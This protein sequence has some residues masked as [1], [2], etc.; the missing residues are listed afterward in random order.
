MNYIL[1]SK[2]RKVLIDLED[3]EKLSKYKW[4]GGFNNGQIFSKEVGTLSRYLLKCPPNLFVDHINH[5]RLDCRKENLR[6]VTSLQNSMN[7]LPK[8]KYKGVS[9]VPGA[10]SWIARITI[11]KKQIILGRY[12]TEIEAAKAY[13]TAALQYFKEYAYLN[14]KRLER[15]D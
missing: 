7:R 9:K 3:Y 1:A 4:L 11:D 2:S 6:I 15:S 5:D 13:D 14:F 10:K 12:S 8:Y